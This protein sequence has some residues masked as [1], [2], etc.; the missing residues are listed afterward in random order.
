M[1]H[2][3]PGKFSFIVYVCLSFSLKKLE[4]M[5]TLWNTVNFC[6]FKVLLSNILSRKAGIK[7]WT[8][9]NHTGD[10]TPAVTP[11]HKYD[12]NYQQVPTKMSIQMMWMSQ[13][14]AVKRPVPLHHF[15]SIGTWMTWPSSRPN[16]SDA[17]V[18]W[19]NIS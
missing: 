16:Q 18:N 15:S 10:E 8:N 3:L 2:G 17:L 11:A 5:G 13:L 1:S 7:T 19:P 6:S 12:F 9:A 4:L 14:C